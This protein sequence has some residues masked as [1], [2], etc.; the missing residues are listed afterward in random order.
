MRLVQSAHSPPLT[1]IRPFFYLVAWSGLHNYTGSAC[2]QTKNRFNGD[3]RIQW[4]CNKNTLNH[5][6]NPTRRSDL[7]QDLSKV[8]HSCERLAHSKDLPLRFPS[9]IRSRAL[10]DFRQCPLRPTTS[11]R[12]RVYGDHRHRQE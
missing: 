5:A 3:I 8:S 4:R 1:R 2:S 7:I 10:K 9:L 12:G 6:W 11:L